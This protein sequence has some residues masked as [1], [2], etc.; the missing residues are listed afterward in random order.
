MVAKLSP[1]ARIRLAVLIAFGVQT[2]RFRLAWYGQPSRVALRCTNCLEVPS[3]L[4]MAAALAL[5]AH[6]RLAVLIA[7][8]V[9]IF[10]KRC[11]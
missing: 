9:Q 1:A 10:E 4:P 3:V 11:I 8:E 6:I 7:F 5:A 2:I